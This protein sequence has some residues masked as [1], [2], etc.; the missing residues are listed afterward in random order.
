MIKGIVPKAEYELI[1]G[2][3]GKENPILENKRKLIVPKSGK[4]IK[5]NADYVLEIN[6]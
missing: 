4:R 1:G 6:N 3:K 5:P 2:T